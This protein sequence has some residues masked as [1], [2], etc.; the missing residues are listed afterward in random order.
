MLKI[1]VTHSAKP[2]S[3]QQK[4]VFK[5]KKGR[6]WKREERGEDSE[7]GEEEDGEE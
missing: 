4:D 5:S 7:E 3:E 1:L 2:V 6:R